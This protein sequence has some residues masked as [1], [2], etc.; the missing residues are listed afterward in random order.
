MSS[1]R[2]PGLLF[3]LA[4]LAALGYPLLGRAA[5]AAAALPVAVKAASIVALAAAAVAARPAAAWL[6]AA[7]LLHATGDALIETAPLPAAMAAFGA[8]HLVYAAL[9]WR[10]RR[11][12]E[13]V[14]GGAKLVVGLLALAAALVLARVAPALGGVLAAAVPLYTAALAAMAAL[15]QVVRRG[16]PWVPAGALLYVVSDTLLALDRFAG[17]LDGARWLVW[18][19][20]WL[21]QA[22]IAFG[23]LRASP[24]EE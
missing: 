2:V 18:P 7:L 4:A 13:E 12:W 21:G 20:Y 23:W 8:G 16:R 6:A 22:A 9:F 19:A 14:R 5:P 10:A 17:P 3:A 15:A 11:S 1:R 24:I